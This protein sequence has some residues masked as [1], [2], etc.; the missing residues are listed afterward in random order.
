MLPQSQKGRSITPPS[1]F[2][3]SLLSQE[4][5]SKLMAFSKLEEVIIGPKS[6][7]QREIAEEEFIATT[8]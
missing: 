3:N 5:A 2:A 8:G 6:L 7:L 1:M 4:Y